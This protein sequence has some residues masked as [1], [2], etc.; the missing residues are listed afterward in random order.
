MITTRDQAA[1]DF[2]SNFKMGTIRQVAQ[3]SYEDDP[4]IAN[5]RFKK[6]YDDK[7]I[8][9][10]KNT[11]DQGYIYSHEKIK[12]L[13][14]YRHYMLRNET[15]LKFL[16]YTDVQEVVVEKT[17]G[18]IRPDMTIAGMYNGEPYLY[19]V[20]CETMNN[21]TLIDYSKYNCFFINEWK[22]YFSKK[23]IVLYVTDKKVFTDRIEY[24]CKIIGQ[25]LKHFSLTLDEVIEE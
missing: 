1:L 19:L 18:S 9:R 13:K 17:F 3:I 2:L 21:G 23:P 10:I 6:F 11:I 24:P 16:A 14:Q 8:T 7:L 25:N 15:Y 4:I 12:S 5:R 22:T 20:E